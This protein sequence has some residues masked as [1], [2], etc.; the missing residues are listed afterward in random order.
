M[1]TVTNDMESIR[2][3]QELSTMDNCFT[4]TREDNTFPSNAA[5]GAK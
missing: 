4:L 1:K 5:R 3:I 2:H